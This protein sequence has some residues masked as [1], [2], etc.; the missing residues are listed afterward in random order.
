[1]APYEQDDSRLVINLNHH[2]RTQFYQIPLK[3][4]M[5]DAEFIEMLPPPAHSYHQIKLVYEEFYLLG[6]NTV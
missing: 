5:T 3:Q 2:I 1:V 4:A 6:H